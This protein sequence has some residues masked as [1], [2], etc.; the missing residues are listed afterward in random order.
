MKRRRKEGGVALCCLDTK[1][2]VLKRYV[3]ALAPR[4]AGDTTLVEETHKGEIEM[5]AP[6]Q[7]A[8]EI[9][10]FR[11]NPEHYFPEAS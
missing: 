10:R 5:E 11:T 7:H 4:W 2:G 6:G 1:T 9:D 3:R 8:H